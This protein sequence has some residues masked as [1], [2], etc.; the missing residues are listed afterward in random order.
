MMTVFISGGIT[1]VP[2]FKERIKEA[3][4]HL[5]WRGFNVSILLDCKIM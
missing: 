3:E 5:R 4:K 2:D 1:D